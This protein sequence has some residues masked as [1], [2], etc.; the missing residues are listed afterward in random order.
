MTITDTTDIEAIA[1]TMFAEQRWPQAAHDAVATLTEIRDRL[2]NDP[3]LNRA[4]NFD[5]WMHAVDRTVSDNLLAL[6]RVLDNQIDPW[7]A[8]PQIVIPDTV[9]TENGCDDL[10]SRLYTSITI[11]GT[12]MHLEAI[13]VR[14][15]VDGEDSRWS[16]QE[17]I[18]DPDTY[19][20]L[21]DA[22]GADGAFTE[23]TIAGRAYI[24]FASPHCD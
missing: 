21:H 11:C 8:A 17:A 5:G 24:V 3:A 14:R 2:A 20:N 1:D 23:T 15:R 12:R 22:V 16:Q 4:R 7:F 13:E 9:W 10:R 19:D 18:E 6:A